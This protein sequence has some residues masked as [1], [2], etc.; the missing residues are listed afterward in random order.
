MQCRLWVCLHSMTSR[1]SVDPLVYDTLPQC[2]SNPT[3]QHCY[4]WTNSEGEN[5]WWT[6]DT[7]FRNFGRGW[8]CNRCVHPA[9][10]AHCRGYGVI[11]GG[12]PSSR[13][14]EH[15]IA[16]AS[17]IIVGRISY[18]E[19]SKRGNLPGMW[20]CSLGVKY[21][22]ITALTA[23]KFQRHTRREDTTYSNQGAAG[24]SSLS[25]LCYMCTAT[26]VL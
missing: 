1:R 12:C 7:G 4:C 17:I 24:D 8:E 13:W 3:T 25:S 21:V 2:Y 14:E 10:R 5:K 16:G 19:N 18:I 9:K 23:M 6:E 26:M 15:V 22:N 11:M 20:E